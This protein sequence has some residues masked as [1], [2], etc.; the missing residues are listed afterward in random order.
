MEDG[1]PTRLAATRSRAAAEGSAPGN[2]QHVKLP[3]D[4]S[5]REWAIMAPLAA[6]VLLLGV[7]PAP[8]TRS[9]RQPVMSAP[10]NVTLPASGRTRPEMQLN[11]VVLPAPF[12]PINPVIRPACTLRSTPRSACTP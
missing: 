8:V 10:S 1:D 12:G 4:A 7:W 6:L 2:A 5:P 11:S 3:P 9:A